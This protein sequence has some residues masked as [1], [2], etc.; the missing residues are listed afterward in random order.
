LG[1]FVAVPVLEPFVEE[2]GDV[3]FVKF[4]KWFKEFF[5]V[6]ELRVKVPNGCIQFA[7]MLFVKLNAL[8]K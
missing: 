5:P 4:L 1:F 3:L 8:T 6:E 7:E 2:D